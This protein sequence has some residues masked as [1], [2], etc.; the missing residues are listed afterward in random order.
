MD[1]DTK[2]KQDKAFEQILA[3]AREAGLVIFM[4][5]PD[6]EPFTDRVLIERPVDAEDERWLEGV[7]QT[8]EEAQTAK[9][10]R[11]LNMHPKEIA[12]AILEEREEAIIED[13]DN[14]L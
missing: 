3:I 11:A 5:D 4:T 7:I 6:D 1:T 8:D 10:L 9:E 14:A 12:E 13:Y 2:A